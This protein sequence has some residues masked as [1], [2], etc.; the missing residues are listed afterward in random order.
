MIKAIS[1]LFAKPK[2]LCPY[3]ES[4]LKLWLFEGNLTPAEFAAKRAHHIEAFDL[5]GFRYIDK[6][7]ESWITKFEE[8]YYDPIKLEEC[9]K[10]HLSPGEY[11]EVKRYVDD[12]MSG[13]IEP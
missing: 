13:K 11:L 3:N 9:R 8:I 12:V 10:Q 1:S 6:K 5:G 2:P 7:L 4:E